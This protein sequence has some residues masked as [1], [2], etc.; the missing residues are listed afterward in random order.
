[1][2]QLPLSHFNLSVE[3]LLALERRAQTLGWDIFHKSNQAAA[4]TPAALAVNLAKAHLNNDVKR[5]VNCTMEV[6]LA[7]VNEMLGEDAIASDEPT[8]TLGVLALLNA[9]GAEPQKIPVSRIDTQSL[10]QAVQNI[11][12]QQQLV[13]GINRSGVVGAE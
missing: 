2:G 4:I 5:V 13:R 9:Q 3:A 7:F 8:V 1:M 11:I 10:N 6:P 12:K